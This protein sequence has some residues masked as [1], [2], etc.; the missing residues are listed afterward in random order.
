MLCRSG[1]LSL[2]RSPS[3]VVGGIRHQQPFILRTDSVPHSQLHI[4]SLQKLHRDG[5]HGHNRMLQINKR[6]TTV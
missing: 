1:V 4:I 2:P 6:C 3:R 5:V